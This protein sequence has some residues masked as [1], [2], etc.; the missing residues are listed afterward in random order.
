MTNEY[1]SRKNLVNI[2]LKGVSSKKDTFIEKT[3]NF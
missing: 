3:S 2:I 1:L